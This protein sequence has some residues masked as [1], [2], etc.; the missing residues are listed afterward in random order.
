MVLTRIVA[1]DRSTE[2]RD[3]A[4]PPA[5]ALRVALVSGLDPTER[6][7]VSRMIAGV[8]AEDTPTSDITDETEDSGEFALVLAERV[9]AAAHA[10][11]TGRTVIELD[12]EADV[13][14]VGFVLEAELEGRRNEGPP[15]ELHD[16]VTVARV[17][18]VHRWLLSAAPAP[19]VDFVTAESL[20]SQIEFAT[21]VVLA[22]AA[23]VSPEQLHS[24]VGLVQRLNPDAAVVTSVA[25]ARQSTG[26]PGGRGCAR[27]I[28]RRMGWTRALA[29]PDLPAASWNGVDVLVFRDP[30]PFHPDRL[31]DAVR[32]RLVPDQVG[33][34]ARSRGLVQ[35]ATRPD[36]HGSWRSAG[37]TVS[38]DPTGI[39]SWDPDAP[40]GQE[41]VFFGEHL[42]RE[43]IIAALHACLLTDDELLA[44]PTIWRRYGD[45]FPAWP[46][47]HDH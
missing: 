1:M 47:H 44:G 26:W 12:A 27:R 13:M 30:R 33:R 20:A 18:D 32:H 34:V 6:A 15:A 7:R 46:L 37:D 25:T 4:R 42:D 41:M 3:T 38:L 10:G 31:F 14:E 17:R 24:T 35:L 21:V 36:H 5:P 45:P 11:A 40:V 16:L 9:L 29:E 8:P 19:A 39:A 23:D 2:A 22:D 43:E 28:G